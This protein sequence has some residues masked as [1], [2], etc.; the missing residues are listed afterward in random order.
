MHLAL[1]VICTVLQ[2]KFIHLSGHRL[3]HYLVCLLMFLMILEKMSNEQESSDIKDYDVG[4][5]PNVLG[6]LTMSWLIYACDQGML[7]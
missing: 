1:I 7:N 2:K 5:E 6:P 4:R 3:R